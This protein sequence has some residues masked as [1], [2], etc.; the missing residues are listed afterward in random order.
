MAETTIEIQ[1]DGR[2][3]LKTTRDNG[4]VITVPKPL[5]ASEIPKPPDPEYKTL[6]SKENTTKIKTGVMTETERDKLLVAIALK[7]GV[8]K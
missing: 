3:Y 6:M 8:L 7:L 2:T 1:Q 4:T 5:P